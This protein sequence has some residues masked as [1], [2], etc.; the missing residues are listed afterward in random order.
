M[1]EMRFKIGTT[2]A[3][4][5]VFVTIFTGLAVVCAGYNELQSQGRSGY[6]GMPDKPILSETN[7]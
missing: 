2:K 4:P 3:L 1:N 5:I 6:F 7:G